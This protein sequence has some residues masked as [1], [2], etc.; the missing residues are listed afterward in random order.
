MR[1]I[2]DAVALEVPQGRAERCILAFFDRFR[3]REGTIEVPLRVD[4]REFGLPGGLQLE[5]TVTV[6]LE[7]RRDADNLNE[8][9]AV[10]WRPGTGEPFPAFDGAIATWSEDGKTSFVELR[11]TYEPPLGSAGRLFDDAIGHVVAK[12]T[13]HQFLQMLAEGARACFQP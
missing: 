2:R 13:V 1:E 7:R 8:E 3:T 10:R 6:Q 5:R 4:L 11:G 9:L 12:R